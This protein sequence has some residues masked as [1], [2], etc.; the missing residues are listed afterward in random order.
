V[1]VRF[2]VTDTGPGIPHEKLNELFRPFHQLDASTTR[3]HGG[4]GLGLAISRELARALNGDITVESS[5]GE[6]STFTLRVT[7]PVHVPAE[8]ERPEANAPEQGP[9]TT[10]DVLP[11]V[12]VLVA[13]DNPV[14]LQ[15]LTAMLRQL[16]CAHDTA[17]DGDAAVAAYKRNEYGL[18]LMDWHMPRLDGAEA[19]RSIRAFEASSGRR[20]RIV[21]VTA[22]TMP[23]SRERC[24][25][26]GMD[27][28][29]TKP[30]TLDALRT[31]VREAAAVQG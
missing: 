20:A 31:A 14:N 6:G 5:A 10:E 8:G 15:V 17:P 28:Y 30:V 13:E 23:G 16:G 11:A 24:L 19:A 29:I 9:V 21:A 18:V 22:D 27:D 26:A 2:D 12:R 1:T 7:A 4:T 25:T 3:V